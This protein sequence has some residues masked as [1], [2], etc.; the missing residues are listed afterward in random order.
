MLAYSVASFMQILL[1]FVRKFL[2]SKF[3]AQYTA[4]AVGLLLTI[5][6]HLRPHAYFPMAVI[7]KSIKKIKIKALRLN[8]SVIK[9]ENPY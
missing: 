6:P 1:G 2:N 4:V 9:L 3:T 7:K 8:L 5:I